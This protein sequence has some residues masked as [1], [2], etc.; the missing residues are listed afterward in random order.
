MTNSELIIRDFHKDDYPEL[1]KFWESLNLSRPERGDDLQIINKTIAL[2]GKLLIAEHKDRI[3]GS[4]WITN[5]GRRLYLHHMG[6]LPKYQG[7]GAGSA[8]MHYVNAF[9]S[10]MK[11]QI[12]LEVHQENI[13]A[14]KLYRK[15]GYKALEGYDVLIRREF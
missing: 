14:Q 5:N 7:Q 12:K 4:A 1:M 15:F 9:A 8:I 13:A 2:G 10:E 3:I 11:M 6:V